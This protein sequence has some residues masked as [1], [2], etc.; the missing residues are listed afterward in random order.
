MSAVLEI[1]EILETNELSIIGTSAVVDV[2]DIK[3]ALYCLQ[4][5]ACAIYMK[6]NDAYKF[7]GS[8]LSLTQ[9]LEKMLRNIIMVCLITPLHMIN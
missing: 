2:N 4:V 5:S 1:L 6:L 8:T 7:S 9:W 3:R